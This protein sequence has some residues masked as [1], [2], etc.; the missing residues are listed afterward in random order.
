VWRRRISTS[1]GFGSNAELDFDVGTRASR[2]RGGLRPAADPPRCRRLPHARPLLHAPVSLRPL[3]RRLPS[4][5][6]AIRPRRRRR[7][8]PPVVGASAAAAGAGV[9]LAGHRPPSC[10][11][12]VV[13]RARETMCSAGPAWD[14]GGSRIPVS[15]GYGRHPCFP[16]EAPVDRCSTKSFIAFL[17]EVTHCASVD[18]LRCITS[19]SSKVQIRHS[20]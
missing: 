3:H 8:L 2:S 18:G 9:L 7:A 16:R 1:S 6:P 12:L 17:Q 11:A 5:P 15:R 13:G 10:S 14:K 20:I 19:E 4:V